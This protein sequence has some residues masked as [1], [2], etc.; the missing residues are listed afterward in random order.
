VQ[1]PAVALL[2]ERVQEARPD[3]ALTR[4]NAEAI[5]EICRR[6]DGLPLALEQLAQQA[7]VLYRESLSLWQEMHRWSKG[8]ASSRGWLAWPR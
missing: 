2:V 7:R 4:E 5:S 3:F 6:L 1:N 8:S